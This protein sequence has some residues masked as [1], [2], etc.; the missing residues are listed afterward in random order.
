VSLGAISPPSDSFAHICAD[1]HTHTHARGHTATDHVIGGAGADLRH[2][3]YTRARDF[4]D[5]RARCDRRLL[6][7]L[8]LFL[9]VVVVGDGQA[10]RT[11]Q[12]DCRG[13]TREIVLAAACARTAPDRDFE[14]ARR[15]RRLEARETY[16]RDR[17][18]RPINGPV[19]GDVT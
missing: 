1:T 2:T 10:K 14:G 18:P 9:L 15:I 17:A 5:F 8:L 13:R 3:R 7:L 12:H 4:R 11:I 19:R 6:L 16:V